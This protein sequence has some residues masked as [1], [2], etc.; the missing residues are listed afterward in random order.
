MYPFARMISVEIWPIGKT[1][2]REYL[3]FAVQWFRM[4]ADLLTPVSFHWACCLPV[5][6]KALLETGNVLFPFLIYRDF[7]HL[8]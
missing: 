4:P 2:T 6:F 3:S 1:T 7:Y 5:G 8:F